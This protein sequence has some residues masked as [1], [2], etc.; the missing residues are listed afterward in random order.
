MSSTYEIAL[1][2]V[3]KSCNFY[4]KRHE[5][6]YKPFIYP[7]YVVR[8]DEGGN[9]VAAI[10]RT[11][12]G[13]THAIYYKPQRRLKITEYEFEDLIRDHARPYTSRGCRVVFGPRWR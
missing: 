1:R 2:P 10:V 8:G 5:A 9:F 12:K 6:S 11:T 13:R 3:P 4:P 7:E